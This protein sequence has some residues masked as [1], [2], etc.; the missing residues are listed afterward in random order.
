MLRNKEFSRFP[1]PVLGL[2]KHGLR[3]V[4]H[5]CRG[6]PLAACVGGIATF[7]QPRWGD[8]EAARLFDE[9][10]GGRCLRFTHASDMVRA[11]GQPHRVPL[12]CWLGWSLSEHG[13]LRWSAHGALLP[14]SCVP[15]AV[16]GKAVGTLA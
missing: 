13:M 2:C 5:A 3:P 16:Q 1:Q 8:A 9:R 15:Q 14:V 6:S 7:G 12:Y 4:G 10:F 11:G